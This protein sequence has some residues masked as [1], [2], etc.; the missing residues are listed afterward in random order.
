MLPKKISK[1]KNINIIKNFYNKENNTPAKIYADYQATTPIDPRVLDT[2][3][4][5]QTKVF[6]NAGSRNHSFGWEAE[7]GVEKARAQVASVINADPKDIIF[8]SGATESTNIAIKGLVNF[9]KKDM[10]KLH[11]I[12]S[13]I[14]HKCVL[15][16]CRALELEGV[17]V[18]YLPVNE[19]GLVSVDDIR[20]NIKENTI[21]VSIMAINNE[22]GIIQPLE[23]IGNLCREKNV[24]F[25]TDA[26]QSYGKIPMDVEKQKIDMMGISGHKIYGPKGIGALYI[27]RRPRVR[28]S[29]IISGGGQERGLR[30]GT[31]GTHLVAG[32]GKAAEI[33]KEEMERDTKRITELSKFLY[34]KISSKIK[35]TIKNGIKDFNMKKWFSGCLNLSFPYV[36]GEGLLMRIKDIALSSGSACTSASLEPSYVLRALGTDDELAHSSI[37]FGIGRFTTKDEIKEI[38]N[39]TVK[40]V[41]ELRELSPLYEMKNEGIDLKS[42]QWT[43]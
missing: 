24:T 16:T 39:K 2:M 26:A 18:T 19:N 22:I 30:S 29:P 27:R 34:T 25:F 13:Q 9:K 14:E 33:C 36:E 15:D 23:D 11:I 31:V 28:I 40:A 4:I 10:D 8:T 42:I 12:T 35:D 41:N 38:A 7:N 5:Y 17:E 37:R 20:K 1:V 43:N 32:L 21:L 3:M 6:G